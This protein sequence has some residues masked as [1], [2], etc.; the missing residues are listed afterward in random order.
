MRINSSKSSSGQE[1]R[2]HDV[3]IISSSESD[4]TNDNNESIKCNLKI[5]KTINQKRK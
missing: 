1:I 4:Y 5:L 3:V 2:N